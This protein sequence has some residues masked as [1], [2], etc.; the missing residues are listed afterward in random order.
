MGWG[1]DV[2]L[3]TIRFLAPAAGAFVSPAALVDVVAYDES[4]IDL[5][6]VVISVTVGSGTTVV[7]YD[8]ATNLFNVAYSGPFSGVSNYTG[9]D[10]EPGFRIVLDAAPDYVNDV[11]VMV[12]V[13][14]EDMAGNVAIAGLSFFVIGAIRL[15]RVKQIMRHK[16]ELTF[17]TPLVSDDALR[18]RTSYEVVP[19]AGGPVASGAL[20]NVH[21]VRKELRQLPYVV[22]LS[23]TPL[24]IGARYR[25]DVL[26]GT[27][28]DL[29][30]QTL[31]TAASYEL[32][33]RRTKADDLFEALPPQW[34]SGDFSNAFWLAVAIAR[35]DEDI[36][37]HTP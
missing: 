33:A 16:L 26:P 13:T 27:V 12:D 5:T 28:R 20:V 36:G 15:V 18:A 10:G 2:S 34:D 7:A 37:G 25:V 9:P 17:S 23:T 22:Y 29:Y 21:E 14:A 35:S 32:V 31:A 3:P 30:G 8:G 24:T 11:E 4:G 1:V 6:T 19:I